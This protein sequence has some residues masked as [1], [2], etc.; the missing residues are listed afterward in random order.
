MKILWHRSDILL[1][2]SILNQILLLIIIALKTL[3]IFHHSIRCDLVRARNQ[4]LRLIRLI[5][6]FDLGASVSVC[7]PNSGYVLIVLLWILRIWLRSCIFIFKPFIRSWVESIFVQIG[8]TVLVWI[9]R[10]SSKGSRS[11]FDFA[12]RQL[13]KISDARF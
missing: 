2:I 7:S 11:L 4:M 13:F 9:T 8:L 5:L 10:C 6:L 12:G 1:R 3:G